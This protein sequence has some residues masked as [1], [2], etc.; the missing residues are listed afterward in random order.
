MHPILHNKGKR[1]NLHSSG[2]DGSCL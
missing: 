2:E 1:K